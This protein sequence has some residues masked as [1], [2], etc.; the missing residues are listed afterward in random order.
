V[1]RNIPV[2]T[3]QPDLQPQ[4]D[5]KKMSHEGA[6]RLNLPK[7]ETD[8]CCNKHI[9]YNNVSALSSSLA[10]DPE[11]VTKQ[12][13]DLLRKIW[14]GVTNA[15][16]IPREHFQELH[17]LLTSAIEEGY[18]EPKADWNSPDHLRRS[19]MEA[20][21]QRFSGAKDLAMVQQLNEL[22]NSA[23]DWP[24]FIEQARP[25]LGNYNGAW[26]KTEYDHA[27]AA[28]QSAA[29]Y[30]RQL[31]DADLYPFWRYDTAGDDRVRDSHAALDGKV[32]SITDPEALRFYPPNGYNC[33]CVAVPTD[34]GGAS[35]LEDAIQAVGGEA[36]E[37]MRKK[38]FDTNWGDTL[39]IFQRSQEYLQGFDPNALS[40]RSFL[41]PEFRDKASLP[42]LDLKPMS[43]KEASAWFGGKRGD[44]G[45]DSPDTVRLEDYRQRPVELHGNLVAD[46]VTRAQASLL[47][48]AEEVLSSPD[49]VWM[50]EGNA[51]VRT[52]MKFF[53]GRAI[54]LDVIFS[55]NNPE[56]IKSMHLLDDNS[57]A[58]I[59]AVRRGILAYFNK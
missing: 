18:P 1:A 33:R 12:E 47:G 22:K 30:L 17:S 43:S 39:R 25:L 54:T 21:V 55:K 35:S 29:N 57:G 59:D 6:G 49:E 11:K 23:K 34:E 19:L 13:T 2:T 46:L 14:E 36:W 50:Q 48:R 32:F 16:K 9:T 37:V 40:Y 28:S 8:P 58:S 20:N 15:G 38:G 45:L 24:S 52:Y 4:A 27:V 31:D 44:L 51:F 5:K 42:R 7:A 41:L 26:L 10:F 3:Q 53:E 56:R